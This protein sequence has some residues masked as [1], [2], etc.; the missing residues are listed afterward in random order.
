MCGPARA[1]KQLGGVTANSRYTC[2][3]YTALQF[4]EYTAVDTPRRSGTHKRHSWRMSCPTVTVGIDLHEQL[5]EL[6]GSEGGAHQA[7]AY[8][9]PLFSST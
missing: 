5:L 4:V 1:A 7:G 9:R 3:E 6:G 8:T 2:V